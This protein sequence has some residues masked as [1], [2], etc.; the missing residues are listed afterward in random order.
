MQEALNLAREALTKGEVPVAALIVRNNEII[1]KAYNGNRNNCDPTAHAEI[2]VLREAGKKI[3]SARLDDCDLYV[4]LEPC[5][6]CAA[7][8]A[9]ARIKRIYYAANDEKF[10]AVENGI[11]FFNSTSCFHVP[12]VYSGIAES[13]A[14]E[15]LR[16]FF[17]QRR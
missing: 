6:M 4:T 14:A 16:T 10:G 3:S 13:E 17:Q 11:R 8:I 1:A 2:L 12:E 7:A 9:L 15:L 5:A